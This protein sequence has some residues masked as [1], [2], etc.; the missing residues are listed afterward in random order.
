MVALG[1]SL[2]SCPQNITGDYEP[3]DLK[4]QW[5]TP[6]GHLLDAQSP[7]GISTGTLWDEYFYHP[8]LA[9]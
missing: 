5:L 2:Y 1:P 8:H 7:R 6:T 4:E 9:D 3:E